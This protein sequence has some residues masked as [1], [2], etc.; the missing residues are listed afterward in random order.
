MELRPFTCPLALSLLALCSCSDDGSVG[1]LLLNAAPQNGEVYLSWTAVDDANDY[2]LCWA[3]ASDDGWGECRS[4]DGTFMSVPGLVNGQQYKFRVQARR[5]SKVFDSASTEAVPRERPECSIPQCYGDIACFCTQEF[6]DQWLHENG[7]DPASLQCRGK[8]VQWNWSSPDCLYFT[9]DRSRSFLLLRA[10]DT[11]FQPPIVPRDPSRV[12]AAARKAL[13]P[14]PNPFEQ[15]DAFP[16]QV[17]EQP[18]AFSGRVSGAMSARSY[19]VIYHSQLSSRITYFAPS[20]PVKGLYAIYHEG[21]GGASVDI[22]AETI[23]W[24]LVRGWQVYAIDMPLIGANGADMTAEL[25]IGRYH[26]DFD[27]LEDA[28]GNSPV[29]LFMLPIKATVDLIYRDASARGEDVQLM[30]IGRSGGGWST[31][32]YSALDPRVALAVSVAGGVPLSQRLMAPDEEILD[33]GDYEQS[34]AHFYNVVSHEDL[35]TTAGSRAALYIHNRWDPCCYRLAPGDA[36]VSYLP[37]AGHALGKA[38]EVYVDETN[39]AHSIG[40]SGYQALDRFID[41]A[42]KAR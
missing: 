28:R 27:K 36:L 34:A 3:S 31:Y 1:A 17:V 13:W 19:T 9:R 42:L 11:A 33:I 24:L 21:H 16:V 40:P 25:D 15:P 10:L 6:A 37:A 20:S 12:R 41:S 18:S 30:M 7:V 14:G 26:D 35:M 32:T 8:Q 2:Q 29:G 4:V 22:G 39:S 23:D 38:I 5:Q